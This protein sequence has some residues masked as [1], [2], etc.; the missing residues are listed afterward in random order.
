MNYITVQRMRKQAQ[1]A[2]IEKPKIQEKPE[3][4]EK[5]TSLSWW[6]KIKK[7]MELGRKN[8]ELRR[9][10]IR[11]LAGS[12]NPGITQEH[13]DQ[14]SLP[15]NVGLVVM[16]GP[17]PLAAIRLLAASS[18]RSNPLSEKELKDKVSNFKASNYWDPWR[19]QKL[20]TQIEM[21]RKDNKKY[22]NVT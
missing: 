22:R 13:I 3:I 7:N 2:T 10:Y 15:A 11:Y 4:P 17:L 16:S 1:E 21:A 12:K 8:M 20:L 5:P 19:H 6:G 9:E 14:A 18:G